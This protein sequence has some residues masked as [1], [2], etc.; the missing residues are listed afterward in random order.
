LFSNLL[1]GVKHSKP[2]TIGKNFSLAL[3]L[4]FFKFVEKN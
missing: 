4:I 2:I 3:E 1:K